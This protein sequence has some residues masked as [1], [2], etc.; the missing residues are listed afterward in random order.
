MD[1]GRERRQ[2]DQG[3]RR[4]EGDTTA[5]EAGTGPDARFARTISAEWITMLRP[6]A[7]CDPSRKMIRL[8]QQVSVFIRFFYLR[9]L[10]EFVNKLAR[11]WLGR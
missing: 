9:Y 6:L 8:D 1:F 4:V 11:R 10:N 5:P 7:W 2:A 3:L